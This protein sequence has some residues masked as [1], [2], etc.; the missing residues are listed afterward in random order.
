LSVQRL[1]AA[2]TYPAHFRGVGSTAARR[3][4]SWSSTASRPPR[5]ST[6]SRSPPASEW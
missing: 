2:R 5:S 4:A 1:R 3:A 6:R